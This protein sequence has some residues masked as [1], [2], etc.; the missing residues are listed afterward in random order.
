M[1]QI[2]Q[3]GQA[4][5]KI[6]EHFSAQ[7]TSTSSPPNEAI[8]GI[9]SA[10]SVSAGNSHTCAALEDGSMR[11]WGQMHGLGIGAATGQ[12]NIWSYERN[13]PTEVPGFS[14]LP[15]GEGFNR[16]YGYVPH[17]RAG[18]RRHAER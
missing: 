12:A 7:T 15:S 5:G 11:C 1:G 14:F 3:V 18:V 8:Y 13:V 9:D 10:I 17:V 2:G 16:P 6:G 4:D